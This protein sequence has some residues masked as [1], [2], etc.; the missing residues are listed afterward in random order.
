MKNHP[1]ASSENPHERRLCNWAI[2]NRRKYHRGLLS[3]HDMR[4]LE[5]LSGWDWGPGS[6][7]FVWRPFD[8]AVEY[9]RSLNIKNSHEYN[10][11]GASNERPNDIPSNPNLAYEEWTTW[12]YWL[13]TE[14]LTYQE[15]KEKSLNA[16]PKNITAWRKLRK[17][18]KIPFEPN[19]YYKDEWEGW[20]EFAGIVIAKVGS[21]WRTYA[22]TKELAQEKGIKSKT[23]WRKWCKTDDR[24]LDIPFQPEDIYKDEWEGWGVFLGT[25]TIAYHRFEFGPFSEC[26]EFA[27]SLGLRLQGQWYELKNR[28]EK[29]PRDPVRVYKDKWTDWDDFLGRTPKKKKKYQ[30]KTNRPYQKRSE[31]KAFKET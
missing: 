3:K 14:F 18:Y 2:E 6:D 16:K 30:R 26:R 23:Q 10:I 15:A 9:I 28:P 13:G 21:D 5:S 27:R 29:F 31:L 20:E 1:R 24:P 12:Q 11:W 22:K 7:K 8:K 4:K 17:T 25:G 19:K